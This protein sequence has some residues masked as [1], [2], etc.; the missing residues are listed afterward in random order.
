[1]ET[2]FVIPCSLFDIPCHR[3]LAL[4]HRRG[5]KGGFGLG[6]RAEA[7]ARPRNRVLKDAARQAKPRPANHVW[8]RATSLGG[9]VDERLWSFT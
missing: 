3:V 7:H 4:R 1:M 2:Y 8:P 5:R 6:S 9:I